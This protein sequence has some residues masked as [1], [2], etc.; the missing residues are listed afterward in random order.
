MRINAIDEANKLYEKFKAGVSSTASRVGSFVQKNP[1]PAAYA[2]QQVQRIAKPMVQRTQQVIQSP[3]AQNIGQRVGRAF[4]ASTPAIPYYQNLVV[5]PLSNAYQSA[6]QAVVPNQ[7]PLQRGISVGQAGLN[8]LGAVSSANPINPYNIGFMAYNALKS[9]KAQAQG[10]TNFGKQLQA[11]YEGAIGKRTTGLGDALFTDQKSR[12]IAN[13]AELPLTIG[14]VHKLSKKGGSGFSKEVIKRVQ[15][16]FSPEVR[17][18]IGE[19]AQLV[20][21][22]PNAN[23]KNL[24]Q[25]GDYVQSLAETVFGKQAR[26][27]TNKQLK[28]SLDLVMKDAFGTGNFPKEYPIGLTAQNVRGNKDVTKGR[29][30]DVSGGMKLYTGQKEGWVPKLPEGENVD[31][32][33]YGKGIYLTPDKSLAEGYARGGGKVHEITADIKNPLTPKMKDWQQFIQKSN[34]EQKR[35]YLINHGYDAVVDTSGKYKQV[36]VVNPEQIIMPNIAQ[37]PSTGGEIGGV[38]EVPQ[39]AKPQVA[40]Q[41]GSQPI[42]GGGGGSSSKPIVSQGID[43]QSYLNELVQKQNSAKQSGTKEGT[44]K[45]LY[46]EIRKKFVDSTSPIEDALSLAEK[47][48]KFQVLPKDD[49]RLQIDRVL[50]APTLAGQF[51]KDNGLTDIIKNTDDL[52]ALDQYMIA[53]HAKT[54]EATGRKTGRDLTRDQQLIQDLAP[55]YEKTAQQVTAYSRKLLDY[56]VDSGLISKKLADKLKTD[57]PEY[58]P[59][60][61]VFDETEKALQGNGRGVASLS[62]QSVVQKLKGSEREIESPIASLLSKTNDAFAQGE[63]NIAGRQLASYKDLPAFKGLITELKGN[64]TG[65]HTFSFIDNGVKRT[66]ETT[67]EIESAAKSLDRQQLGFLGNILSLSTR[68]LRLGATGLNIPF[69][70]ANIVKDQLT[71]FINSNKAAKTSLLNPANFLRAMWSAG[72]HDELYDEMVRA[73]AGGTSFDIGRQNVPQTIAKIR[74]GRSAGSKIAYTV[75]HPSEIITA[76]ENLI[77]RSEELGRLQQFR[78]TK[79]ALQGRTV[80][81]ATLLAA[82]AARENTAN[83]ARSGDWGKVLN[84]VIPYFN[85]GIQG[86]RATMKAL[87]RDPVGTSAKIATGLFL[88]VAGAT[89]W[90]L[91]DSARKAVYEDIDDYEKENN[92]ILVLDPTKGMDKGR[93]GG[94]IKIPIQQGFGGLSTG[95]RKGIEQ[96][97]GLAPAKVGE[98]AAGLVQFGTSLNVGSPREL[99]SSLTP[100]ALKV[101]IEAATNTNLFTGKNIV[102]PYM[103]DKPP[104]EQVYDSTS[105]TARKIG[106]LLNVSPLHVQN[107]VSTSLGGVGRQL[108]NAS[109]TVLNKMGA[110]PNSQVG[111]QSVG[112]ATAS[113]FVSA[114]G[115]KQLEEAYKQKD[116][117]DAAKRQAIQAYLSE[118]KE[119]ALKIMKENKIKLSNDDIKA[120]K[121]TQKK[122]AADLFI[123]DKKDNALEIM[124]K[125]K[126][127]LEPS[128]VNKAAKRKAVELY[129]LGLKDQA[130]VIMKK[131]KIHLSQK[132]IE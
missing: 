60:Q 6:K 108:L 107:A 123:E 14:M 21:N 104:E 93:Y 87:Q 99:V 111:G 45:R 75:T 65:K 115:G 90:N 88:P 80:Q 52:N 12:D 76:L 68:A 10:P 61:R 132:D 120:Y 119:G 125:Y 72:K 34:A 53:K 23:K 31:S 22:N 51:S 2:S 110:I 122:K 112:E 92:I 19:F 64:A 59:L 9:A 97:Y 11:T 48:G 91:S 103:K 74:S 116:I 1:L 32:L 40:L 13:L 70:G 42:Q 58:V 18:K 114:S 56:S 29:L 28:N 26:N 24:G 37:P 109:D 54:I 73:G 55:K 113:R 77:G 131:Y 130:L 127:K 105:G 50:R 121:N 129:K 43:T 101:P 63:R 49:V 16:G 83:F 38:I 41:G 82:Q 30:S 89:M 66:F 17:A 27:M 25:L 8:T 67:P 126:I 36:M 79:Q 62:R 44:I 124:K 5:K 95:V 118:D 117:K 4:V 69:V 39:T 102:S 94:V 33:M 20:E 86:S 15:Q 96:A 100:Q 85:A 7:T 47:K 78:G 84:L 57:Y 71:G 81:D 3:V 35:Q 98:I 128:D 106:G 46:S